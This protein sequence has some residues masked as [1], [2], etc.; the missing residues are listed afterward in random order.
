MSFLFYIADPTDP[1]GG[2]KLVD[3]NGWDDG[4]WFQFDE[5]TFNLGGDE[6]E[7][8]WLS[9]QGVDGDVLASGRRPHTRMEFDLHWWPPSDTADA[10]DLRNRFLTLNAA[11]NQPGTVI[12]QP[13][14]YPL[15]TIDT[16]RSPFSIPF[17]SGE[18]Q[19]LRLLTQLQAKSAA[20]VIINRAPKMRGP[21]LEAGLQRLH[22]PAFVE[23]HDFD[24]VPS[25][26]DWD[27]TTGLSALGFSWTYASYQFTH[28]R[29]GTNLLQQ[30]ATPATVGQVW[31]F[32]FE[33]ARTTIGHGITATAR[34]EFL[35]ASNALLGS[36]HDG[37]PVSP[38]DP[39]LG[40][41]QAKVTA[42][43]PSTT[44]KIRVS[45]K[46]TN[47]AA[48]GNTVYVRKAQAELG[49]TPSAF[50]IGHETI[51]MDIR[52]PFG[53]RTWVWGEGN[54]DGLTQIRADP[55]SAADVVIM[56]ESRRAGS[57]NS[58]AAMQT[59][60]G[61]RAVDA[62]P[63]GSSAPVSD[64][65][66]TGG[67]SLE[68]DVDTV[69]AG[70]VRVNAPQDIDTALMGTWHIYAALRF[71]EG[72]D[73]D[74]EFWAGNVQGRYGLSN[75][76][77]L[78]RVMRDYPIDMT[79]P[80]ASEFVVF[81]FG[82]VNIPAGAD[83]VF[84]AIY[85]RTTRGTGSPFVD[86]I[87]PM[88][89]DD[90]TGVTVI[91]G[92]DEP[93]KLATDKYFPDDLVTPPV[94]PGGLNPGDIVGSGDMVLNDTDEAAEILE[95]AT[96]DLTAGVKHVY[97]ARG[98]LYNPNQ[99]TLKHGEIVVYDITAAA[100]VD[101]TSIYGVK[102]SRWPEY[103]V[104]VS[105]HPITGHAYAIRVQ[106]TIA[107]ADGN[108]HI[109]EIDHS[110]IPPVEGGA[111]SIILDGLTRQAYVLNSDLRTRDLDHIPPFL[112][113]EPG[114]QLWRVFT[115]DAAASGY[116]QVSSVPLDQHVPTE[117]LDFG[118]DQVPRYTN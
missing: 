50:R 27:F 13:P 54:V 96:A 115:L 20:H 99:T 3:F 81:D 53:M 76:L 49:S 113:T 12:C 70:I 59:F 37:T 65:A 22:N 111:D 10:A 63:L 4:G 93:G 33:V 105:F 41:T 14:G 60:P 68:G 34:I 58:H 80:S 61:L 57:R 2:T 48:D 94:T 56:R 28:T 114:L 82:P 45:L 103:T 52:D 85:G 88:P 110:F 102:G 26:W 116:D 118:V 64:S 77:D 23:D 83:G 66:G 24:G 101:H 74:D 72:A 51:S 98:V 55:S 97:T 92:H 25:L 67:N 79:D 73:G 91:S 100:E 15:L 11:L 71:P 29:N 86:A 117:T 9:E 7:E 62:I 47:T 17:R 1:S 18:R 69:Y 32:A 39:A 43:A 84:F 108:I 36:I 38:T 89:A 95:D 31:T 6:F 35:D 107:N 21:L 75:V 109:A 87:W 8:S 19:L 106:Q 40:F 44:A 30:V 104:S 42:T 46:I 16:F 5:E 112:G 90:E 78:P